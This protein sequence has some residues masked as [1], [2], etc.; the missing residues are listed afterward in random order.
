MRL[1]V[2]FLAL[3]IAGDYGFVQLRT[4]AYTI[5]AVPAEIPFTEPAPAKTDFTT[6]LRPI[7]LAVNLATS[8]AE[9]C[10]IV[11]LLIGPKQ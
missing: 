8:T 7:L 11:Y 1:R 6:Q 5:A 3:I 4:P 2:L 10:T 9:R